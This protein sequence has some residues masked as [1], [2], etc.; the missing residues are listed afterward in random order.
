M[1]KGNDG[2]EGDRAAPEGTVPG[3]R[4]GGTTEGTAPT[5]GAAPEGTVPAPRAAGEQAAPGSPSGRDLA[6]AADRHLAAWAEA[7]ADAPLDL[8]G[9]VTGPVH[10]PRGVDALVELAGLPPAGLRRRVAVV[11]ATD[12]DD[13]AAAVRWAATHGVVIAVAG[14][15]HVGAP[16][17]PVL[18]ISCRRIDTITVDPVARTLRA[19]VGASWRAVRAVLAAH[20]AA[21]GASGG[22]ARPV[23][24]AGPRT[25]GEAVADL[26]VHPAL[27]GVVMVT[28]D[29]VVRSVSARTSPDLWWTVRRGLDAAGIVTEVELAL[30][31]SPGY[32][33]GFDPVP[34]GVALTAPERERFRAVVHRHDPLAILGALRIG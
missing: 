1:G 17:R 9:R 25:V 6:A 27:R 3:P 18:G 19:G 29:S 30:D 13:V 7:L 12:T 20:G 32:V 5:A 21:S 11:G 33:H 22:S 4:A 31:A 8:A 26:G 10:D 2:R 24:P 14:T 23:V 15:G 16:G 34:A 28:A